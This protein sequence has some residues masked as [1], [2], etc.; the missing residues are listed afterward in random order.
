MNYTKLPKYRIWKKCLICGNQ[1]LA[2]GDYKG[3]QSKYCSR[4]CYGE[5]RRK[6]NIKPLITEE[7]NKKISD[8]LKKEY[9][10][11]V[12]QTCGADFEVP[13]WAIAKKACNF[14]SLKCYWKSLKGKR[15]S[16]E[17]EFEK[18]YIPWCKGLK[19]CWD[20]KTLKRILTRRSPNKEESVLIELFR[21]VN[22]PYKYVGNGEIIIG[23]RNPDFINHDGKKK[24]IEFFGEHWHK[25]EDE[26]IKRKIYKEYGFEMLGIWGKEL[27]NKDKLIKKIEEFNNAK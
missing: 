3:Y 6:N 11:R 12:C 27:E 13:K 15:R 8:S 21:N 9:V 7:R 20:D 22:L 24:I 19:D 25:K 23:G 26:D 18:G 1:F 17:T 10:K 5:W 16:P 4:K 14:C 2:K